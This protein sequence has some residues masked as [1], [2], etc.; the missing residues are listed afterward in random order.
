L[1]WVRVRGRSCKGVSG[2]AW[3]AAPFCGVPCSGLQFLASGPCQAWHSG[4]PGAAAEPAPTK[5]P[6]PR[7]SAAPSSPGSP[8]RR[9]PRRGPAAAAPSPSG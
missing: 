3:A 1:G 7:R 4:S 8:P 9:R 6:H 5:K 2:T